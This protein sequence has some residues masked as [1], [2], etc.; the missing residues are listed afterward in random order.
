MWRDTTIMLYSEEKKAWCRTMCM[1]YYV[2]HVERRKYKTCICLYRH[3]E[4]LERQTEKESRDYI[5]VWEPG[6]WGRWGRRRDLSLYFIKLWSEHTYHGIYPLN[7]SLSAQDSNCISLYSLGFELCPWI[8]YS[9]V[10]CET[11]SKRSSTQENRP[12]LRAVPEA[13]R[14]E[15]RCRGAH[16]VGGRGGSVT[17]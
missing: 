7:K 17:Q 8:T 6:G 13:G 3:K 2:C 14:T 12:V 16:T 5:W 9:E 15:P 4:S 10:K 11:L 1:V